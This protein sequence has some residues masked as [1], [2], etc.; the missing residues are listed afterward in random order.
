MPNERPADFILRCIELRGKLILTFKT[1]GE[2]EHDQILVSGVFLRS[3]ESGLENNLNLQ[4]IRPV[5]RSQGVTDED[6]LS[7]TKRTAAEERDRARNFSKRLSKVNSVIG[8]PTDS[9]F[10]YSD[11]GKSKC[12]QESSKVISELTKAL[13]AVTE[14]LAALRKDV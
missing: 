8:N 12:G 6:I 1:S 9:E 10:D 3:V 13:S 5:L 11:L 14:Q 4:E 2:I 7:A